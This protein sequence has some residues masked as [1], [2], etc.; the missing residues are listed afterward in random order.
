MTRRLAVTNRGFFLSLTALLVF[1]IPSVYGADTKPAK[2]DCPSCEAFGVQRPQERKPAPAF[3]L[4][5]LEGATVSLADFK[6]K[7]V[8]IKFW[9]TWCP[10]C[11]EELPILERLLAGKKDQLVVLM[12]AIDGEKES[13]VQRA[14]KKAKLTLP[15]LLDVKEKIAR[16]YGVTFIPAAFLIDRD[17]TIAAKIVGERD[18]N[19][20][21]AW[22][23]VKEVFC[24]P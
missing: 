4:K 23:A 13:R 24:L 22:G 17:G 16:T 15:V 9:A 2:Q 18:W 1:I 8:F 11:E 3:S 6:G 19:S 21:A 12:L 14:I 5:T 7:P 10:S 20:P